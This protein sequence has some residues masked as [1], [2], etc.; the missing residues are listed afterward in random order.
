MSFF[1][2]SVKRLRRTNGEFYA[3]PKFLQ[4]IA[5]CLAPPV[6]PVMRLQ[7]PDKLNVSIKPRFA[8]VFFQKW[9][10]VWKLWLLG[11]ILFRYKT[12]FLLRIFKFLAWLSCIV[13]LYCKFSSEKCQTHWSFLSYD[14]SCLAKYFF[15]IWGILSRRQFILKIT[16]FHHRALAVRGGRNENI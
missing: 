5:S 13:C 6:S 7:T 9:L 3:F 4:N 2:D 8:S 11:S 16:D 1:T 15:M 14:C 10:I 12:L